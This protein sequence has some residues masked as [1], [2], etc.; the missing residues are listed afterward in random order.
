[1]VSLR[2]ACSPP[3]CVNVCDQFVCGFQ[4]GVMWDRFYLVLAGA[5]RGGVLFLWKSKTIFGSC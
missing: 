1:M 4:E 2:S 5:R 3:K